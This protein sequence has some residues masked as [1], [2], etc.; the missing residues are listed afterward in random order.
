MS[1]PIVSRRV[2]IG[3]GCLISGLLVARQ[4]NW[5]PFANNPFTGAN[6]NPPAD[7]KGPNRI[8][9]P[10]RYK[11]ELHPVLIQ[12][13]PLLLNFTVRGNEQCNKLTG[14]L[15]R[16]VSLETDKRVNMVDIEADEPGTLDLLTEYRVTEIPTVVLL[17]KQ[18]IVDHY[19]VPDLMKNTS[20][21]VDWIKLKDW[22]ESV[23]DE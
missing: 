9:L 4:F 16:I 18:L 7:Q 17:R 2:L 12:K 13:L 11:E 21:E 6:M 23:A 8:F 14:A 1:S 20:S 5:W 19:T 3:T 22:I 10:I 15:Q